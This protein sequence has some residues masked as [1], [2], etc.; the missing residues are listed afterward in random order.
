MEPPSD[1][2]HLRCPGC[3][4][5]VRYPKNRALAIARSGKEVRSW[6][7]RRCNLKWVAKEGRK[8]QEALSG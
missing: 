8:Q 2:V 4:R 1:V 3:N 6:C 7:S 5:E